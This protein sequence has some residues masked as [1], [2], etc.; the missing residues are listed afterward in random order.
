MIIDT[1][2][3]IAVM[4]H[5]PEAEEFLKTIAAA[6]MSGISAAS[7]LEMAIVSRADPGS[8]RGFRG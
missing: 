4:R 5:E 1:S 3:A 6:L 2:A 8:G 7:V